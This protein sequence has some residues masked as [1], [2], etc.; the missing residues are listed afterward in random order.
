[1]AREGDCGHRRKVQVRDERQGAGGRRD[2]VWEGEHGCG[3]KAQ[4]RDER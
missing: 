2:G 4:V 1:V 3:H